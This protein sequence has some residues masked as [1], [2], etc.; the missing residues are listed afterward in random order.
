MKHIIT[1]VREIMPAGGK[2]MVWVC[3]P[4]EFHPKTHN[5]FSQAVVEQ[6]EK[7]TV[8]LKSIQI[9]LKELS[10]SWKDRLD[11]VMLFMSLSYSTY[12]KWK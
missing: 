4:A 11:A 9:S 8:I 5:N 7:R 10:Q 1:A 6:T 3:L 12:P 2:G